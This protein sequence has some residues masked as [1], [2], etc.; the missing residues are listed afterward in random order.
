VQ[1]DNQNLVQIIDNSMQTSAPAAISATTTRTTVGNGG[2]NTGSVY[3]SF[4]AFKF[5]TI[6][7]TNG[8]T[9]AIDA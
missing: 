1:C 7:T 2:W 9:R 3:I 6:V 8:T 4:Y 5:R